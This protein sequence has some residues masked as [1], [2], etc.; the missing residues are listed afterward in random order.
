MIIILPLITGVMLFSL[1]LLAI[2]LCVLI[3]TMLIVI[4]LFTIILYHSFYYKR[5]AE[6]KL[7]DNITQNVAYLAVH[8]LTTT[9]EEDYSTIPDIDFTINNDSNYEDIITG[10]HTYIN[11]STIPLESTYENISEPPPP[12]VQTSSQESEI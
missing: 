3:L 9:H 8:Q 5:K 4:L 11:T 7:N 12:P 10:E 6:Q 1:P 2:G